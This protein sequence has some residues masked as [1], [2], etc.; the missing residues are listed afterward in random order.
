M[1][2]IIVDK[3]AVVE[4]FSVRTGSGRRPKRDASQGD[5]GVNGAR[6]GAVF[7][8]VQAAR[9]AVP[10]GDPGGPW[11]ASPMFRSL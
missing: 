10:V 5:G 4:R 2:S 8:K 6:P 1:T 3:S 9:C 7:G 11:P